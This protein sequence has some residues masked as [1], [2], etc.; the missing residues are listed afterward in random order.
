MNAF[1]SSGPLKEIVSG[2]EDPSSSVFLAHSLGNMV[3]SAAI[4]DKALPC[5]KYLMVDAAVPAEAYGGAEESAMVHR[6]ESWSWLNIPGGDGT[7]FDQ[8]LTYFGVNEDRLVNWRD[9]DTTLRSTGYADLFAAGDFR[10]ALKWRNRFVNVSANAVNY[11][12]DT[13]DVLTAK[14][15]GSP[16]TQGHFPVFAGAQ[17]RQW[18]W[19]GNEIWKGRLKTFANFGVRIRCAGWS[20][21]RKWEHFE[22]SHSPRY[23]DDA[24]AN[25]LALMGRVH[26][27]K[28]WDPNDLPM[29][30]EPGAPAG[31]T[32]PSPAND[33]A[34]F[35]SSTPGV[36]PTYSSPGIFGL[37][38]YPETKPR[39]FFIEH[40]LFNPMDMAELE[41]YGYIPTGFGLHLRDPMPTYSAS[42]AIHYTA[43]AALLAYGIPAMSFPAGGKAI[44]GLFEDKDFRMDGPFWTETEWPRKVSRKTGI[45]SSLTKSEWWHSDFINVAYLHTHLLWVNF[46]NQGAL[47]KEPDQ[48]SAN[49]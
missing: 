28:V 13:E 49:P 42:D 30:V 2:C 48:P 15:S 40:P 34:T 44:G 45:N 43:R 27:G 39:E 32:L 47:D 12:S 16:Y 29:I 38:A 4:Q 8:F 9:Y 6:G 37:G 41:E 5:A 25:A 36:G 21:S 22:P 23:E 26:V 1:L 20:V 14:D 19:M 35:L 3:V 31:A 7:W 33:F 17:E 10:N 24:S 18:I 46:V 11:F